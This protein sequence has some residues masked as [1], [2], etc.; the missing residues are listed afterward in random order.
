VPLRGM[1]DKTTTVPTLSTQTWTV[2][3]TGWYLHKFQQ[4]PGIIQQVLSQAVHM[5]VK[6]RRRFAPEFGD[7]APETGLWLLS[8]DRVKSINAYAYEVDKPTWFR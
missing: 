3:F 6:L 8:L 2:W 5:H 4:M 7:G 1:L